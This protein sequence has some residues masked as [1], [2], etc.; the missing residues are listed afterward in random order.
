[1]TRSPSFSRSSSSV[2]MTNLPRRYSSIA[3]GTVAM[4]STSLTCSRAT[5]HPCDELL[6]VARDDV[7]VEVDAVAGLAADQVRVLLGV[8]D[9]GDREPVPVLVDDGEADSID[10]D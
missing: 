1:M 10:A 6:D 3:S 4:T 8:L 7:R 2:M 9:E 5:L